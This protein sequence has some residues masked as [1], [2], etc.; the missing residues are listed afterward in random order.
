MG[1]NHH[2]PLGRDIHIPWLPM[3]CAFCHPKR[4]PLTSTTME[5]TRFCPLAACP[6]AASDSALSELS[7]NSWIWWEEQS[8]PHPSGCFTPHSYFLQKGMFPDMLCVDAVCTEC[9]ADAVYVLFV[10]QSLSSLF[11][12]IIRGKTHAALSP[13]AKPSP[14]L[15]A[16]FC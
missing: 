3:L 2:I 8:E 7:Q 11:H 10:L 9:S 1:I 16:P 14:S 13:T 15:T 12:E 5:R 4:S 6:A